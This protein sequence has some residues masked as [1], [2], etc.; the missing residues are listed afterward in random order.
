MLS[1]YLLLRILMPFS[2]SFCGQPSAVFTG[3]LCAV[4]C[5]LFA[6]ESGCS[7]TFPWDSCLERECSSRNTTCQDLDRELPLQSTHTCKNSIQSEGVP[8]KHRFVLSSYSTLGTWLGHGEGVGSGGVVV[9]ATV[10]VVVGSEP[11]VVVVA[12]VV[13]VDAGVV[14]VPPPGS[15]HS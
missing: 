6:L 2:R 7:D 12:A 8:R 15:R 1:K 5:A 3:V 13:V 14:V 9:V 11:E 10:V 4:F